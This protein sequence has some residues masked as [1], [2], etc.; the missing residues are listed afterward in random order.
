MCNEIYIKN[1]TKDNKEEQN[2]FKKSLTFKLN[3][4]E[5]D[6]IDSKTKNKTDYIYNALY[7]SSNFAKLT[8]NEKKELLMR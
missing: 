2:G 3:F 1:E 4:N 7:N 6:S 5:N 8:N